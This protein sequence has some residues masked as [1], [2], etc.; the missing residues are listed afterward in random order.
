MCSLPLSTNPAT[1]ASSRCPAQ[2][3]E[4][5]QRQH[6]A[7]QALA[8]TQPIAQ[9]AQQHRVSRKYVYLQADRADQ[10]LRVVFD[11]QPDDERVLFYLPVTKAWL[12]QLVLALVLIGHS[13]FRGVVELLRDLFDYSLSLGTVY[14]IVHGAVS[15]A[16]HHN[17]SQDLAAIRLAALDEI[18]QG[19]GP[20]LVSCDVPSSYC[21]LL[22]QEACRD[23]DTWGVRLLELTERHFSPEATIAD[24]GLGL[25]A[26]HKQALPNVPCR[27]DVFH[28]LQELTP[29]VGYLD[30]R[31]YAAMAACNK[32]QT[33][34]ARPGQLRDQMKRKW[35]QR[36]SFALVVQ[37][38]AIALAEDVAL[39]LRWLREDILAVS[40]PD[41]ASRGALYDFVVAELRVREPLCPHRL[42]PVR[43][44]L[45]K[46]RD[47]LLAFAVQ[48]DRDLAALAAEHQVSVELARETLHVQA[49]SVYDVQRGRR[50]VLLWRALASRYPPLR[51]AIAVLQQRVVRASSVVENLNSRLRNYFTLR[52]HLGADYL[53]LLQFF[54]NHRRFLR[55]EHPERVDRSPT[56]LLTGQPHAHWLELLGYTRFR[57]PQ[58]VEAE[59]HDHGSPAGR[60]SR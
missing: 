56:E 5:A 47:D 29:L 27:G 25:R 60:P 54:L 17:T 2:A 57:R 9:L 1:A 40:G 52:R 30:N 22:S 21:C 8:A 23:G 26:G 59:N 34:L 48:L 58:R 7:V 11:P 45:E 49:L 36:L 37:Q 18:F 15:R 41:Y 44:Q 46:Q 12:R 3:L 31:A 24:G 10:A 53:T 39:L 43:K 6:L 32:L 28:A 33:Q 13:S 42:E 14:N 35:I 50:E 38:K 16:H 51:A 20:V 55:S 19:N 4:P